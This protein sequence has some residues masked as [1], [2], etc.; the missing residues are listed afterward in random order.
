MIN[1]KF[2]FRLYTSI[3]VLRNINEIV[4]IHCVYVLIYV[5]KYVVYF[6]YYIAQAE[7]YRLRIEKNVLTKYF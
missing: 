4:R 1:I 7:N 5:H 2:T 3:N 6:I